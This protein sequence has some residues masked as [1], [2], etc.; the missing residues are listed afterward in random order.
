MKIEKYIS[1]YAENTPLRIVTSFIPL[2]GSQID[3]ILSSYAEN[4][5]KKR[6]E[7]SLRTLNEEFDRLQMNS[8]D[9]DFIQS[10]AFFDIFR[11]YFEKSL[12]IRQ[13]EKVG[14]Y[15]KVL[16][17]TIKTPEIVE[18]SEVIM[19]KLSQLQLQ[20]LKVLKKMFNDHKRNP[21]LFGDPD[22]IVKGTLAMKVVP[23]NIPEIK[24]LNKSQVETSLSNLVSIGF[25]KEHV[26]GA[27]GYRGG[28]YFITSL[29][30]ETL[31]YFLI[32]D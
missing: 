27:A 1:T 5:Y 7:K 30:E 19:E 13:E 17:H 2:F 4:I 20:D 22:K 8:I 15:A 26:G 25:V 32:D 16:A 31:S 21:T 6:L 9:K 23:N 28:W 24:D 11:L 12:R 10:E 14:Y 29:G 18:H 3:L